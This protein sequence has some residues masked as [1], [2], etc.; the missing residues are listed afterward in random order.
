MTGVLGMIMGYAV[1]SMIAAGLYTW[2]GITSMESM[3]LAAIILILAM[4]PGGAIGSFQLSVMA[5][6]L[7]A[8]GCGISMLIIHRKKPSH[9]VNRGKEAAGRFFSPAYVLLTVVFFGSMIAFRGD[10][11]QNIDDFHQWAAAV[12]YMLERGHLPQADFL[13][14][15]SIPAYTGVFHLFFQKLGGYNEGHMYVS[16][17]L[18]SAI[19]LL[20]PVS[21]L[22]KDRW[23]SSIWYVLT[24]YAGMYS[25]YNHPYKSLYVDLPVAAWAAGTCL[26][27][28]GLLTGNEI[29]SRKKKTTAAMMIMFLWF[30]VEI[31][32]GTGFLLAAFCAFYMLATWLIWLEK[33]QRTAFF[34]KYGKWIA[35]LIMAGGILCLVVLIK[36]VSF[37]PVSLGGLKEALTFSSEKARLTASA[38]YDN[39]LNKVLH[40]QARWKLRTGYVMAVLILLTILLAGGV[41]QWQRR[42]LL[43]NAVFTGITFAG[44]ILGLYATYVSLF[45]YEESVSNAAVHRYLAIIVLFAFFIFAGTMA[46]WEI[47]EDI[48]KARIMTVFKGTVVCLCIMGLTKNAINEATALSAGY[49][50]GRVSTLKAKTDYENMCAR[51]NDDQA[52]VYI[53]EQGMD[54]SNVNELYLCVPLY[55]GEGKVSNYLREP[56]AFYDGGSYVMIASDGRTLT[57]LPDILRGGGY[58]H[59][60]IHSTNAYLA[61]HLPQVVQMNGKIEDDQLYQIAVSAD[62]SL[63]LQPVE[64]IS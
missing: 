4:Y 8:F 33:E 17:V 14:S 27:W 64:G 47:N 28:A 2:L 57:D 1:L 36:G 7:A 58:T 54:L 18:L 45:S 3:A 53:L 50:W 39:V 16:S 43:F 55:Y 22:K 10:M 56:W 46:V 34:K 49:S 9:F 20:L 30:I 62:G 41:K 15:A 32:S 21:W 42:L 61:E 24:V 5:L 52:K 63:N 29:H 26:W 31:K 25:L 40:S 51:L 59:L 12:K 37:I 44:Y 48:G 38:L 6:I 11:L 19:A 23:K 35:L 13:G 60:W